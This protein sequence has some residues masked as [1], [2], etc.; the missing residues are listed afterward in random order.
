MKRLS[1]AFVIGLVLLFILSACGA[2]AEIVEPKPIG[3]IDVPEED[4]PFYS[5]S[6]KD[7]EI[8]IIK[9]TEFTISYVDAEYG[10]VYYESFNDVEVITATAVYDLGDNYTTEETYT[11]PSYLVYYN[12]DVDDLDELISEDLSYMAFSPFLYFSAEIEDEEFSRISASVF[13]DLD[14]IVDTY[15]L[16]YGGYPWEYSDD[17]YYKVVSIEDNP[18]EHPIQIE[19]HI[20]DG[21]MDH[22]YDGLNFD[23]GANSFDL[24]LSLSEAIAIEKSVATLVPQDPAS[25]TEFD[26]TFSYTY[27]SKNAN[28][29]IRFLQEL[30]ATIYYQTNG[31]SATFGK[32]VFNK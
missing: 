5:Y 19:I 8:S 20:S 12:R 29:F 3:T 13:N 18:C 1:K 30:P 21:S 17:N 9:C 24:D 15:T 10:L 25:I 7:D 16:G 27:G 23:D 26:G 28:E 22:S 14:E 11:L 6:W 2:A 32:I 4:T 31:D